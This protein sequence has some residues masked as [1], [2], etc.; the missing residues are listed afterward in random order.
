METIRAELERTLEYFMDALPNVLG[1][2]GLTV[3]ALILARVISEF[4]R[5]RVDKS[6]IGLVANREALGPGK[7]SLGRSLG[8][9]VFWL[10]L[11][12]FIPWVLAVLGLSE[13]L[14]PLNTMLAQVMDYLPRIA[15]AGFTIA[16]GFVIATV[17]R[18]ALTSLLSA[19]PI[20]HAAKQVNIG[21]LIKGT[22]I[23][24]AVGLF[25]YVGILIPTFIVGLE[26]LAIES[27]SAPL[28]AMLETMLNAIPS[29]I[30]AGLVLFVFT[31]FARAVRSLVISF[32]TGMGFDSFWRQLGVAIDHHEDE[33]AARRALKGQAI[34]PTI[35]AANIAMAAMLIVGAITAAQQLNIEPVSTALSEVL[36]VGA[37][38]LLGSVVILAG[39]PVSRFVA[40]TLRRAGDPRSELVATAVQWGILVLVT[41]I[42]VREMG[43]GE[44][45]IFAGFVLILGAAALA[46]ALAFGIGGR[47][48]AARFLERLDRERDE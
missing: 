25:A 46:A 1:A 38:I 26:A 24:R 28:T 2:L 48:A 27:I 5:K 29:I 4:V 12:M 14:T 17:A 40:N 3:L 21:D 36:S 22:E 20:D 35:I 34:S 37:Q 44:D 31:L 15:L 10:I 45:I 13:T 19:A 16:V 23:A 9:A 42:G 47:G 6:K 30:A 43:L 32:L 18:R 11:L 8:S 41:A 7:P 33:E 39:I